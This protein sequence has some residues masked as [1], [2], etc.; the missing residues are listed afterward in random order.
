M[1]VSLPLR[2]KMYSRTLI[3]LIESKETE[4]C[5]GFRT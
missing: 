1:P 2:G 3:D 5:F 4:K